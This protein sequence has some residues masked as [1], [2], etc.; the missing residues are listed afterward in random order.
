[1]KRQGGDNNS[2]NII[3]QLF[4]APTWCGHCKTFKPVWDDMQKLS[5]KSSD[6]NRVI[7]ANELIKFESYDDNHPK[8]KQEGISGF[9]SLFY[10]INGEKHQYQGERKPEKM[11]KFILDKLEKQ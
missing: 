3:I 2:N 5:T 1:M 10:I 6:G 11:L 9:P 4:E 7:R 8:T